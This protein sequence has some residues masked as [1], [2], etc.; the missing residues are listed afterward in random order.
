M[1]RSESRTILLVDDD[2]SLRMTLSFILEK[3]EFDVLEAESA[4]EARNLFSEY[5][6]SISCL[7]TDHHL[8]DELGVDLARSLRKSHQSMGVIILS[9]SSTSS[10]TSLIDPK[11]DFIFLEKPFEARQILEPLGRCCAA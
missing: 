9:G 1:L 10:V 4:E 2:I 5:G 8:Q 11:E 3:S 7:I 6:D